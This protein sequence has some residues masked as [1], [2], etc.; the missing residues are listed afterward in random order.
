[1]VKS[2]NRR[3]VPSKEDEYIFKDNYKPI[4]ITGTVEKA[5]MIK[6]IV[7]LKLNQKVSILANKDISAAKKPNKIQISKP[8]TMKYQPSKVVNIDKKIGK[9]RQRQSSSKPIDFASND[10]ERRSQ[11]EGPTLHGKAHGKGKLLFRDGSCFIGEFKN[12][13]MSGVGSFIDVLQSLK[14]SG[15]WLDGKAHGVGRLSYH[16]DL[17]SRTLESRDLNKVF[18]DL[19]SPL[20]HSFLSPGPAYLDNYNGCFKFGKIDG[21]GTGNFTNGVKYEGQWRNST[22]EGSGQLVYY[23]GDIYEGCFYRDQRRGKA[24]YLLKLNSEEKEEEKFVTFYFVYKNDFP[25]FIYYSSAL[26][27][28]SFC[29]YGIY[30]D[31]FPLFQY[32][33]FGEEPS[34]E[35]VYCSLENNNLY[36]T[37]D[38]DSTFY[39]VLKKSIEVYLNNFTLIRGFFFLFFRSHIVFVTCEIVETFSLYLCKRIINLSESR[40]KSFRYEIFYIGCLIGCVFTFSIIFVIWFG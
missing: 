21:V 3:L 30:V 10:I 4:L 12:D 26:L 38:D 29:F 13:K 19:E 1:M 37:D 25:Q 33:L 35:E 16:I 24:K 17:T 34:E 15:E 11:Y 14:Y 28:F 7:N 18:D 23:Y 22:R 27:F 31:V 8:K 40:L 32:Y 39:F 2:K 5:I 9:K 36:M 20:F 6:E